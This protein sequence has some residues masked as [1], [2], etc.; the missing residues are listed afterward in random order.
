MEVTARVEERLEVIGCNVIFMCCVGRIVKTT[1]R[2]IAVNAAL[3]DS[4]VW[5]EVFLMT[6]NPVPA[7]LPTQRISKVLL[8]CFRLFLSTKYYV[9]TFFLFAIL[10]LVLVHPV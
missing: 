4:M 2:A 10:C 5:S 8:M 3:R 1:Q 6:A 7:P 9:Y